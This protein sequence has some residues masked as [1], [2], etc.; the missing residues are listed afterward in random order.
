MPNIALADFCPQIPPL[1]NQ[2]EFNYIMC[3]NRTL[4]LVQAMR[5]ISLMMNN[6]ECTNAT[7]SFFCK[8]VF[9]L[10]SDESIIAED[11]EEECVDVRDNNCTIEWRVVENIF[12]VSL[13][14]CESLAANRTVVWSKAPPLTCPE[15]FNVFCNSFCLPTCPDFFQFSQVATVANYVLLIVFELLGIISGV[16]TLIACLFN[17]EKM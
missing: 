12:N 6:E 3:L 8:A 1:G 9:S 10:C 5:A 17:R 11:L 7:V 2:T 16:I 13:P 15:Q 14:S 4:S